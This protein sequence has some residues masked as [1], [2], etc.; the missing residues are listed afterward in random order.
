V[1]IWTQWQR[2]NFYQEFNSVIQP[3]SSHFIDSFSGCGSE[4]KNCKYRAGLWDHEDC[5]VHAEWYFFV[6]GHG[7]IW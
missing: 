2:E 6:T 7:E 5:G 1:L 4:Y 3:M